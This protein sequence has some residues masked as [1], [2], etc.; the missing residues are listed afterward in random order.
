MNDDP[1]FRR[2]TP[3]ELAMFDLAEAR[4]HV[5]K[6]DFRGARVSYL[7]CVEEWRQ[8]N[9]EANGAYQREWEQAAREYE[10]F[11]DRDPVFLELVRKIEPVVRQQPG[12][13]QTELYKRLSEIPK[14]EISYALY[15]AA[16]QGRFVR[17]RKGR[18]YEVHPG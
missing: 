16:K 15:F 1:A 3:A 10:E 18:T 14:P 4:E 5:S 2:I 8:A 12:I 17:K 6:D 9:E 7:K 11:V 13:L